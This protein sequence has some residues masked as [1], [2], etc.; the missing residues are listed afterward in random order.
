[1][2]KT[3]Q[4]NGQRLVLTAG[5]A[6]HLLATDPEGRVRLPILDER[7]VL[8]TPLYERDSSGFLASEQAEKKDD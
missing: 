3:Y 7:Q 8:F 5:E 1:M 2:W 4:G 6:K